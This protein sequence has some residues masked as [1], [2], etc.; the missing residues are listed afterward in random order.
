MDGVVRVTVLRLYTMRRHL[1]FLFRLSPKFERLTLHACEACQAMPDPVV[2]WR[3]VMERRRK[4]W[5]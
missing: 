5:S 1:P 3:E 2:E 4:A